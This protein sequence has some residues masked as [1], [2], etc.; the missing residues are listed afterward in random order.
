MEQNYLV[1]AETEVVQRLLKSLGVVEEIAEDNHNAA[2]RDPLG[3]L[4]ENIRKGRLAFR[5]CRVYQLKR[6]VYAQ[7]LDI[8]RE[9]YSGAIFEHTAKICVGY[10]KMRCRAG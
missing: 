1:L 2:V 8:C 4:V 6:M 5:L 7:A 3:N 10:R 9:V